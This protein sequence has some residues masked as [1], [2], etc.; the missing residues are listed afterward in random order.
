[1][2]K[3]DDFAAAFTRLDGDIVLDFQIAWALN[4]DTPGDKFW[5]TVALGFLSCDSPGSGVKACVKCIDFTHL[6]QR[7][8][9]VCLNSKN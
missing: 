1:M 2:K 5:A 3:V 6:L 9:K 7:L 8:F 4:M